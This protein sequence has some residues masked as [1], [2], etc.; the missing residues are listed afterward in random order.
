VIGE[1]RRLVVTDLLQLAS[2][3]TNWPVW[4]SV[5]RP[6]IEPLNARTILDLGD[7]LSEIFLSTRG[8]GGREQADLSGGGAA[9][10]ALICWYANLCLV[11]TTSVVIKKN[12]QVPKCVRDALTVTY[13]NNATNSEA[14]LVAITF[15]NEEPWLTA[16]T[17]GSKALLARIEELAQD[18]F[19]KLAV[20]V[21]QCKTNWND[22]AQ[23]PMLWDMIYQAQGFQQNRV[24]VGVNQHSI[25]SL[26][27][28]RYAFITVPTSKAPKPG[29]TAVARVMNLSGGNYW[30]RPTINQVASSLKEL[31]AKAV[32]GPDAGGG[33][34]YSLT[35][36]VGRI[37]SEFEY[38]SI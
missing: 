33:I 25:R 1:L 23:I 36:N 8:A 11:G 6:L 19:P 22:N 38:F 16:G 7:H 17:M 37:R 15:P 10:E 5:W 9:W 30:G 3:K 20:S 2:V 13:S 35:K 28:F 32:V 21:I 31:F 24:S 12:S 18:E 26:S 4:Q 34:L 29:S 14:D 27:S